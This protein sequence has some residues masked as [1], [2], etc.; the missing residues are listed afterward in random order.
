MPYTSGLAEHATFASVEEE[1]T[2]SDEPLLYG[3]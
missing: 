1:L 2:M 3:K